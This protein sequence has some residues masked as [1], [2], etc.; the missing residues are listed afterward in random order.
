[1][2]AE[3]FVEYSLRLGERVDTEGTMGDGVGDCSCWR[4]SGLTGVICG[5]YRLSAGGAGGTELNSIIEA[6][7]GSP[8]I[9]LNAGGGVLADLSEVSSVTIY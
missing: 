7:D 6:E 5:K 3:A 4:K 9:F 8:D 1:M 2:D